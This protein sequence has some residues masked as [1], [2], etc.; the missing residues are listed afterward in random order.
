MQTVVV[1][2]STKHFQNN[3]FN[4]F[5]FNRGRS[6]L[7]FSRAEVTTSCKGFSAQISHRYK[8][9]VTFCRSAVDLLLRLGWF[10]CWDP[11]LTLGWRTSHLTF[12]Y[13]MQKTLWSTQIAE[14]QTHII[15]VPPPHFTFVLR[16]SPC[17][18]PTPNGH[19]Y[20]DVIC[21]RD[22]YV[23]FSCSLQTKVDTFFF[24]KNMLFLGT[25]QT[26]RVWSVSFYLFCLEFPRGSA[27]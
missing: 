13:L 8:R 16:V 24:R 21:L 25:F 2:R 12:E 27:F 11:A 1:F 15:T 17:P 6:L 23:L 9:R 26:N 7:N 4:V 20:F 18:P 3:H 22:I 14:K 19:L 5:T 10:S